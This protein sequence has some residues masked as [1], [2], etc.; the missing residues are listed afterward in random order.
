MHNIAVPSNYTFGYAKELY[1]LCQPLFPSGSIDSFHYVR[2]Y[3]DGRYLSLNTNLDIEKF[4]LFDTKGEFIHDHKILK[5]AFDS[6]RFKT[7]RIYAFTED[8]DD[9]YWASMFEKLSI[10]SCFNIIEKNNNFYERF[11]FISK[12]N[13]KQG[14]FYFNEANLLENFILYFKEHGADLIKDSEKN[15]FIWLNNYPKYCDTVK[16]L[17][18]TLTKEETYITDLKN[19]FKLKKYPLIR[20]NTKVYLTQR[21]LNC[22]HQLGQG[23]SCKEIGKVL[24]LS[25][26]TIE[27]HLQNIKDKLGIC[28]QGELLKIYHSSMLAKLV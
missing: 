6:K 24:Q 23:F 18:N 17:E 11:S 16:K 21:E 26:R 14:N 2:V 10:K 12:L 9:G 5:A 4:E 20:S 3:H 19:S 28:S 7:H 8:I 1:N 27:S 25:H 15:S 22:L 13:R